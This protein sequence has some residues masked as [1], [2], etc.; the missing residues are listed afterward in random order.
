[1]LAICLRVPRQARWR[2]AYLA[3]AEWEKVSIFDGLRITGCSVCQALQKF[4]KP[5]SVV[6]TSS[7]VCAVGCL[8]SCV[9]LLVSVL[10]SGVFLVA[11]RKAIGQCAILKRGD[12][13]VYYMVRSRW[14]LVD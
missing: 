9:F 6:L 12:R 8:H 13:F 10:T 4:S 5:S 7:K 14:W 11:Q 1:M 3:T 2:I